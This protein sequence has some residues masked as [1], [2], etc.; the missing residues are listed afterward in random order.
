MARDRLYNFMNRVN[1]AL[2]A[3][4]WMLLAVGASALTAPAWPEDMYTAVGGTSLAIG[5]VG[6]GCYWAYL[7][8]TNRRPSWCTVSDPDEVTSDSQGVHH[9]QLSGVCS[10]ER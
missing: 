9:Q 6:Q 3:V 1:L 4:V 2:L 7:A 10:R 8:V 5:L